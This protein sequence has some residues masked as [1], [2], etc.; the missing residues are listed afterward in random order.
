VSSPARPFEP[1]LTERLIIRA[2]VPGDLEA[3]DARRNDP[4]VARYQDW[5][6]PYPVERSRDCVE[7]A[8]A[9]GGLVDGEWW[10]ATVALRSDETVVGDLA[11]NISQNWRAA[12]VGYSLAPTFWGNGYA[13]EALDAL[14]NHLYDDL[15]IQR[16]SA[17][18]HP[19]NIAS[20]M[21]L[22]RAGFDFEGLLKRSFWMSDAPDAD[23]SDDALY[24]LVKADRDAWR[25][26]PTGP[27]DQVLLIDVTSDN[28]RQVSELVTHKSQERL[29]A[30]VLYSFADAL[31]ASSDN[32]RHVDPRMWAIEADGDLAGFVMIAE[33]TK[34]NPEPYLWRLLID[35]RFQ[36]RGIG[37]RAVDLVEEYC[38]LKGA[39]SIRVSWDDGPG[40]PEPFYLARGYEPT[41]NRPH[42]EIEARKQ[43]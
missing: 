6:I 16:V 41:G 39:E 10:T 1:L 31:F 43:L 32:D 40:S 9:Q 22:E 20:A 7:G 35:R 17:S 37:G 14:L 5:E 29:V 21:L 24:G 11:I 23:N 4:Q 13:S 19:D 34:D 8:I 3:F 28:Q 25:A 2:P 36:R 42:D 30:P 27:A 15:G 12:E 38:R 18:L 33:Q 26:R